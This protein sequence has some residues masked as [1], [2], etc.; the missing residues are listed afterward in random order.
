M[1]N[2]NRR[3][4]LNVLMLG[5]VS[6]LTD[7]SS[8][9][10]YPL[11][12]IFV[13]ALGSGPVV[14][15]FIEGV[16]ETTSSMLKLLVGILSDRMRKRKLFV[17]IGYGIS[18]LS[19][20]LIAL[21]T[22]AWQ[23]VFVRMSDR[24]GKGIRTAPRDAL[25]TLTVDENQRGR[26]FGF[27]RA[28]DHAGAVAGPL[29]AI[30]VLMVI[31]LGFGVSNPETALRMMFGLALVPGILAF[32]VLVFFVRDRG[33]RACGSPQFRFSPGLFDG[34]FRRYLLII[35]LFTL[36]NS[37]DAFLL[38]RA[39]EAIHDSGVMETILNGIGPVKNIVEMFNGVEAR[40]TVMNILILPLIWAFF[41]VIKVLFSTPFGSLSDRI[42]RKKVIT[43]GWIVYA[44]VYAGFAFI[45]LLPGDK[46]LS[47]IFVL[48]AVY[49][50]Y[51]ALTE[52]VEKAFVAD[53]VKGENAGSAFGMYNF[54]VGLGALPSS[55]I[56]GFIY[57][58]FGAAAAFGFGAFLAA[59]S[60]IL[61]SFFVKEKR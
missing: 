5:L 61:L 55:V 23:I 3:I 42:G 26:A 36:G 47:A 54:C 21:V 16:A 60:M 52:G 7:A 53:M 27:H 46:R 31:F 17:L 59:A 48:F 8:E 39:G 38:F 19:R 18:G 57:K 9:M 56:F 51:Y 37:S 33:D 22:Q 2:G 4:P 58:F 13:S 35:T 10:I 41:H 14:L 28:M 15:G 32:A 50:L 20:P 34:N 24:V 1:K 11:I 29:A 45:H 49:A 40:K 12:P 25:I 44:A 6:F 30:A 43:A